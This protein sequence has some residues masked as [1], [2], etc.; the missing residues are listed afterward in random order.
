ML[1]SSRRH[2]GIPVTGDDFEGYIHRDVEAD[3]RLITPGMNTARSTNRSAD[4]PSPKQETGKATKPK[5]P[6]WNSK[7]TTSPASTSKTPGKRNPGGSSSKS[8][9]TT[10]ARPVTHTPARARRVGTEN[11]GKSPVEVGKTSPSATPAQKDNLAQS[12]VPPRQVRTVSPVRSFPSSL[13]REEAPG[14]AG[15]HAGAVKTARKI[16]KKQP[17]TPPPPMLPDKPLTATQMLMRSRFHRRSA[18]PSLQSPPKVPPMDLSLNLKGICGEAVTERTLDP[19]RCDAPLHTSS[20]S[21]PCKTSGAT[22]IDSEICEYEHVES[23]TEH[24]PEISEAAD[25]DHADL[26]QHQNRWGR[27]SM[28][29]L[30]A[31]SGALF[32]LPLY[33]KHMEWQL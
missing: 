11:V 13:S 14:L 15:K 7:T 18:M 6:Q 4:M 20:R 10:A 19:Q 23:E 29:G 1:L 9:P 16:K 31:V 3:D 27:M 24:V 21:Q 2:P 17:N 5:R 26:Q 33:Q 28:L 22:K 25:T 8:S 32:L 30:A 12:P